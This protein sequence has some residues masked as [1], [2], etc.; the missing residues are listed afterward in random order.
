MA[1]QQTPRTTVVKG[2]PESRAYEADGKPTRA[3]E[4]FAQSKGL[5]VK[6]LEVRE[7]DGGRYVVALVKEPTRSAFDV[8]LEAL[9]ALTAGIKFEKSM[10][11]NFTNVAFSRP[12]RWLLAMLGSAVIPFEYAGLTAQASTQRIAF[13]GTRGVALARS[14]TISPV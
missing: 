8:L 3:L 10:R 6:D 14:A 1:D 9:P 11:W 5:T 12:V 2:P 13:R 4:G 7:V